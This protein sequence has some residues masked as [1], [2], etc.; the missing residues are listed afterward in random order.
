MTTTTVL[1][2]AVAVAALL[3]AGML[4]VV[5]CETRARHRPVGGEAIRDQAEENARQVR[6]QEALADESAVKAHAAQVEVDIKS[7][8]ACRM[9]R[10]AAIHRSEATTSRDHLNE[11]RDHTDKLNAAAQTPATP[12]LAR[13]T[14]F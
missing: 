5:V 2:P 1:I 12:R 4:A 13:L 3:L 6:R 7:A 14:K 10:Q 8:R 11:L 9:H